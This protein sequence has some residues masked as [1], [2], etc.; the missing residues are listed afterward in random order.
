MKSII[1]KAA[2][3]LLVAPVLALS[4]VIFGAVPAYAA[5]YDNLSDCIN[6]ASGTEFTKTPCKYNGKVYLNADKS[7]PISPDEYNKKCAVTGGLRAGIDCGQANEDEQPS[8]LFGNGGIVTTIINVLLFIIGI[9]CVIMIIFGGI[10]YTTSTGDK[11][12]VDSAKNT[13]IYAVVGLIVA[14]VAYALVNWVFGAVTA[15]S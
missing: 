8:T 10:R 2:G 3:V 11:N 9:L 15:T 12:R 14:I 7:G 5:P 6:N 1:K 4:L 13:I